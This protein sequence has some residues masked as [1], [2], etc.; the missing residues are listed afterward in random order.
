MTKIKSFIGKNSD[1]QNFLENPSIGR[2]GKK[3]VVESL[4]SKQK[5]SELVINLFRV[6]AD[7]GRL[8]NSLKVISSFEQIM[9]A[10]HSE[11]SV[12][13]ISHKVK[14]FSIV[15]FHVFRPFR[16]MF[17]RSLKA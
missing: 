15:I 7:N 11:I 6:M 14:Q 13:I 9:K 10:H 3:K 16:K 8:D 1:I 4:L 12:K 2:E 17:N 5:Y